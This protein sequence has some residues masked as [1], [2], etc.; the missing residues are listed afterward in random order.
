M[1]WRLVEAHSKA[2]LKNRLRGS[3][4]SPPMGTR[5]DVR[6]SMTIDDRGCY[7]WKVLGMWQILDTC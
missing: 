1:G 4:P 5:A 2:Q 7:C 3:E 6:V